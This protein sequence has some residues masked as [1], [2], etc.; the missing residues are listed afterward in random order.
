[1]KCSYTAEIQLYERK[2]SWGE[3]QTIVCPFLTS[4]MSQ[5]STRTA[6]PIVRKVKSPTIL[7]PSEHARNTP[8]RQSHVHHSVENSLQIIK[9]QNT[10]RGL[11]R[12]KHVLVTQFPETNIRVKRKRD[13]ENQLSVQEDKTVLCDVCIIYEQNR[14]NHVCTHIPHFMKKIL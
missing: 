13:E 7:Q 9:C 2:K 3:V 14:V 1:M 12:R 5:R 4:R 8:V 11:K 6:V 10:R